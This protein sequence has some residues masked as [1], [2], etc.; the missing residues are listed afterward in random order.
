MVSA[1]TAGIGSRGSYFVES[2][3]LGLRGRAPEIN[4]LSLLDHPIRSRQIQ[5]PPILQWGG[6]EV[7]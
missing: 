7:G 5:R 1:G 4:Q 2:G 3:L 6:G